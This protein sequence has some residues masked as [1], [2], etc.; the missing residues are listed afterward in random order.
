MQF[1]WDDN[2]NQ[3]NIRRRGLDFEDAWQVFESPLLA[4]LNHREDYGEDRWQGIGLLQGRVVVVVFTDRAPDIIHIISLR[5]ADR[6]ERRA[7]E[8]WLQDRLGT[9]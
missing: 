2:K 5:K 6:D 7:Y 4:R 3:E 9:S 1:T 8:A